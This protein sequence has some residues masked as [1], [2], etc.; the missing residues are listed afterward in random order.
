MPIVTSQRASVEIKCTSKQ[1]FWNL[2]SPKQITDGTD[3]CV[4]WKETQILQLAYRN[5]KKNVGRFWG[6]RIPRSCTASIII[7]LG[8]QHAPESAHGLLYPSNLFMSGAVRGGRL[9][10]SHSTLGGK[11]I[12]ITD[13]VIQQRHAEEIDGPGEN[14]VTGPAVEAVVTARRFRCIATERRRAREQGNKSLDDESTTP[15]LLTLPP[16]SS[17]WPDSTTDCATFALA[18]FFPFLVLCAECFSSGITFVLAGKLVFVFKKNIHH[19]N[20]WQKTP[21]PVLSHCGV[22]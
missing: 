17:L 21:V 4:H 5:T 18:L 2:E 20:N 1:A 15:C 8:R 12:I 11:T 3:G 13:W 6:W 14:L 16:S 7:T 9:P 22:S 19:S 10:R